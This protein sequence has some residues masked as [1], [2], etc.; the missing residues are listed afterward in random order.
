MTNLVTSLLQVPVAYKALVLP[1]LLGEANFTSERLNLPIAG[2]I[3]TQ[4]LTSVFIARPDYGVA[5]HVQTRDFVFNFMQGS[6]Y[7]VAR[8]DVFRG[9][10]PLGEIYRRFQRRTNLLDSRGAYLLATQWLAALDVDVTALELRHE[11]SITQWKLLKPYE[12]GEILEPGAKSN[13]LRETLLP[14]FEIRWGTNGLKPGIT[15]PVE[16]GVLGTTKELLFLRLKPPTFSRRPP[17]PLPPQ[18][19][20]LVPSPPPPPVTGS[21]SPWR[22]PAWA[23]PEELES[24]A[25][26][27]AQALWMRDLLGQST[28]E[29]L[30]DP[31]RAEICTIKLKPAAHQSSTRLEDYAITSDWKAISPGHAAIWGNRFSQLNSYRWYAFPFSP[32]YIARFQFHR[33]SRVVTVQ[34]DFLEGYLHIYGEKGISPPLCFGGQSREL[35]SWF[36]TQFPDDPGLRARGDNAIPPVR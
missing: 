28:I 7:S 29:I 4:Q 6:L 16:V 21:K 8:L 11:P 31:E 10:E 32:E 23:P 22:R 5:G 26:A 30:H 27:E 36:L 24:A 13:N 15:A 18:A 20:E 19:K 3:Q 14:V 34:V 2:V 12:A 33:G 35:L 1:L 25:Q 17:I 9:P